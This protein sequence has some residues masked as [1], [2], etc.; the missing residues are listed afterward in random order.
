MAPWQLFTVCKYRHE[1]SLKQRTQ[2]AW[3]G[4]KMV[5]AD[6]SLGIIPNSD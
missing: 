1:E 6:W 2:S 5:I 4:Q 3:V